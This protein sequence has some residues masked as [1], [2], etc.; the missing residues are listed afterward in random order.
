[1]QTLKVGDSLP[2]GFFH[3]RIEAFDEVFLRE[4]E[5][6]SL[7]PFLEGNRKIRYR[8]VEASRIKLVRPGD[9]IHQNRCIPHIFGDRPDLIQRRGKGDQAVPRNSTVRWF[10]T[11]PTTKCSWLPNRTARVRSEGCE[12]LI[13]R[14]HSG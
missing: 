9:D 2:Y 3:L 12:S 14:H 10:Q 11:D 13:G 8:I 6:Q 4:T 5:L 7:D 1:A